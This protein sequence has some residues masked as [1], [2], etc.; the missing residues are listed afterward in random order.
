MKTSKIL[1]ATVSFL[2]A[3]SASAAKGDDVWKSITNW[4]DY[5]PHGEYGDLKGMALYD[6][7]SDGINECIV[8]GEN[9]NVVL[10]CG[11]GTGKYG[12]L[13]VKTA[14]N[15]ISSTSIS[16]VKNLPYLIQEGYLMRTPR[17]REV[18]PLAYQ[19]LGKIRLSGSQQ[20]LF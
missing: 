20:E 4:S 3:I 17:G 11:D 16:I 2:F 12:L 1:L 19:H 15:S 18:T 8:I 7:D 13:H 5:C 6:I 10:T 14:V 9:G